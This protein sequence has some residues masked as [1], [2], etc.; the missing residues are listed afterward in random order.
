[1]EQPKE[2]GS[3]DPGVLYFNYSTFLATTHIFKPSLPLHPILSSL[4]SRRDLKH[5]G[6]L[7]HF[8][9]AEFNSAPSNSRL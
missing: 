1:M 8:G 5:F 7:S 9:L 3:N 2:I 6:S 4:I